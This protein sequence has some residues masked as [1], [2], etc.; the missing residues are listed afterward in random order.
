MQ[1]CA[2][3]R[4]DWMTRHSGR[5]KTVFII[6]T[7]AQRLRFLPSSENKRNFLQL[8]PSA[9]SLLLRVHQ[10]QAPRFVLAVSSTGTLGDGKTAPSHPEFSQSQD[11]CGKEKMSGRIL[12]GCW[13]RP[14]CG[15]AGPLLPDGHS[16]G[17]L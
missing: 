4:N 11:G 6:S 12:N 7:P 13:L 5:D 15:A 16:L 3:A 9:R 14:F 1:T 17:W 10:K 8:L 2:A